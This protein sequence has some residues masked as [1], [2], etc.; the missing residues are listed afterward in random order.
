[1]PITTFQQFFIDRTRE[2]LITIGKKYLEKYGEC[3][4]Y[5]TIAYMAKGDIKTK[6]L[7]IGNFF[8]PKARG[9]ELKSYI[10]DQIQLMKSRGEN[11]FVCFIMVDT[12]VSQIEMPEGQ[13][14]I[15]DNILQFKPIDDPKRIE[16]IAIIIAT[17]ENY[18]T[19]LY[20]YKKE[21]HKYV[22]EEMK[23]GPAVFGNLTGVFE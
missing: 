7:D 8:H 22:Y 15:P 1:M 4:P 21:K 5:V 9:K 23:N 18:T 17:A 6:S 16:T 19:Y 11:P 10:K 20:P 2:D 13:K 12:W 3:F 14:E